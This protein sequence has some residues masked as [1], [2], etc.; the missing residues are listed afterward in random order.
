M[1]GPG[2]VPGLGSS[3][4]S[5][6]GAW[7]GPAQQVPECVQFAHP[8]G[9]QGAWVGPHEGTYLSRGAPAGSIPGVE[10]PLGGATHS[11]LFPRAVM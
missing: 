9:L 11:V 6:E 1:V 10:I 3:G 2:S 7:P 5:R 4:R 8:L